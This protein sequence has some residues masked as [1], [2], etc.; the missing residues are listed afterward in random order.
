VSPAKRKQK[1]RGNG[2]G[3]APLRP[4]EFWR[5]TPE[6]EPPAPV[7]PSN[8]PTA[9]IRSLGDPPLPGHSVAATQEL[10]KVAYLSARLA[11]AVAPAAGIVARDDEDD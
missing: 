6:L 2:G 7:V 11:T 4:A 8:D 1:R 5:A 3:N 9:L 10:A